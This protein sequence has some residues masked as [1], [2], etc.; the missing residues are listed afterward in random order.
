MTALLPTFASTHKDIAPLVGRVH[1]ADIF[2]LCD[3]L[4]DASVDMILCD[5]PYGVH[6]A[7]WDEIIKLDAMWDV[8]KRIIKP[9]HAIVLTASDPFSTKLKV[10]NWDEYKY[11]WVW[12]KSMKGDIMNAKNKPMRKHEDILVFSNGTTANKSLR[13]MPYFPQGLS[14]KPMR[15]RGRETYQ[16]KNS[17]A[18]I[19]K[20]RQSWKEEYI[21]EYE[22]YPDTVLNF[23]HS[24]YDTQHPNQKPV[25]LFEYLIKTYTQPGELVFDPCAGSGTTAVAARNTGREFIVGDLTHEYVLIARDRLN[26]EFGVKHTRKE[27]DLAGLP[28]FKDAV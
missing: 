8:F 13:R 21:R 10:S 1:H 9:L 3:R 24:N 17:N 6:E 20:M 28:L 26:T 16:R 27:N 11:S 14:H 4:P 18:N 7:G 2:A 12:V 23:P 19:I 25:A 22:N 5:L 15:V